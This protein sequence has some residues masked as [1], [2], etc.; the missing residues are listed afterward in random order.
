MW[1]H[2]F[3]QR[4]HA[5]ID[6]DNFTE[7]FN[8]VFRTRYQH[9]RYDTTIHSLVKL[10][11]DVVYPEQEREYNIKSAQLT[12]QYR[13]PRHELPEFLLGRPHQIQATCISNMEKAREIKQDDITS[14]EGD[15]CYEV[16]SNQSGAHTIDIC[17]GAC[18]CKSF[19]LQQI[20][21]KHMFAVFSNSNWSWNDLPE[22]LTNSVNMT[23]EIPS[24]SAHPEGQKNDEPTTSD[25]GMQEES[26][27]PNTTDPIPVPRSSDYQ[28]LKAQKHAR[29]SLAKCISAVFTIED[30]TV[31]EEV[32]AGAE[33]LYNLIVSSTQSSDGLP[34]FPLLQKAGIAEYREKMKM[35]EKARR[36]V[37]KYRKQ[38]LKRTQQ[39]QTS[40]KTK[41]Y[42]LCDEPLS[43]CL[44]TTVGRPKKKVIKRR[45]KMVSHLVSDETREAKLKS[46]SST[47]VSIYVYM[48]TQFHFS[49]NCYATIGQGS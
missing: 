41:K 30:V 5:G 37:M 28:L 23:L 15:G 24:F 36:T 3:R 46:K 39:S 32:A 29:D 4:F 20:P 40:S 2:V 25:I 18:T 48:Y 12:T 9:L 8:N 11:V 42:N 13:Q 35:Q 6:T 26:N 21:C 34:T 45:K 43:Q 7:S 47:K 22:S 27:P 33:H 44:K 16:K 19:V 14:M 10:L 38:S 31:C 17:N 49:T 1:S